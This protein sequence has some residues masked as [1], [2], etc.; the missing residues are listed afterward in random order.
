MRVE[1]KAASAWRSEAQ[2]SIAL[3]EPSDRARSPLVNAQLL[4]SVDFERVLRARSLALTEHFAMHYLDDF[5]RAPL[6]YVPGSS[7]THLS[8]IASHRLPAPVNDLHRRDVREAVSGLWWGAVV[9]KRHARRSVTRTLLK[10]QIRELVNH[11]GAAMP[12]GLCV[13]RL[14]AP[15]DRGVFSSAASRELKVA[16]RTELEQL[17][18]H[19]FPAAA[20]V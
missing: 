12:G 10:R 17:L 1:P 6:K 9:P 2:L 20:G 15:F 13:V 16:A 18:R 7:T 5:P 11:G 8:T 14:R 4:K 3:A 19:A